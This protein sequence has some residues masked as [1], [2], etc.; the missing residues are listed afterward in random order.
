[1]TV[2]QAAFYSGLSVP[3]IRRYIKSGKLSAKL[4]P[5]KYGDEYRIPRSQLMEVIDGASSLPSFE[6][7]PHHHHEETIKLA[8]QLGYYKG[9]SEE[10]TRSIQLLKEELR[11]LKFTTQRQIQD[12]E[13][14]VARRES[15]LKKMV[16]YCESLEKQVDSITNPTNLSQ[17]SFEENLPSIESQPHQEPQPVKEESV[18]KQSSK[19]SWRYWLSQSD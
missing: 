4:V 16:D 1:M 19:K 18:E 9:V 15:Q 14:L 8:E 2:K 12:L 3:T 17:T 7:E 13:K 11:D 5:G 6:E 10:Q